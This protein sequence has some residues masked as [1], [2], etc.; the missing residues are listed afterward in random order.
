[1]LHRTQTCTS[2]TILK[3]AVRRAVTGRE[4]HRFYACGA[5]CSTHPWSRGAGCRRNTTTVLHDLNHE[6][7]NRLCGLDAPE[8]G[9]AFGQRSEQS[10]SDCWF[11]KEAVVEGDNTDRYGRTVGRVVVCCDDCNLRQVLPARA[12][13]YVRYARE[14]PAAYSKHYS[15]VDLRA[16]DTKWALLADSYAITPV[17]GV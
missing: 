8:G 16:P 9:K 14:R 6:H 12:P 11:G 2:R 15:A 17:D 7:K 5:V 13:C 1:L 4:L 3:P 10:L